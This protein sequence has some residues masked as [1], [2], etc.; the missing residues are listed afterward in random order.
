MLNPRSPYKIRTAQAIHTHGPLA[1]VCLTTSRRIVQM[2]PDA[3]L[4]V[5]TRFARTWGYRR[6]SDVAMSSDGQYQV[7]V[8][9][10]GH[11][12]YSNDYGINWRE[13][14]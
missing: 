1:L 10:N 11:I 6:W 13:N 9:D 12:W 5:P 4:S 8:I 3:E 7:A 2:Q 14:D